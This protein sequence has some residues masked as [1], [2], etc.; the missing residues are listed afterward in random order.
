MISKEEILSALKKV[1]HPE[2]GKDIVSLGIVSDIRSDE[3]GISLILEPEKSND[4]FISSIK[5]TV[6]RVIKEN[7]GADS[8]I[9]SIEVKPRVKAEKKQ[10]KAEEFLSGIR[11]IIAISSG[12][13]GVGKTTVAVNLAIALARKKYSVG[14][15][16]A[17]VFGPSVPK[18]LGSEGFKPDIK[19]E[20]GTDYIV[21]LVKHGIKILSTGFFVNP[22]DAVIWRG[23]MASNFLKQ[24]MSQGEWGLLDYMLIDLPPGTGDIHLTLV[25]EVAVTGVIVVTT[26]Q[27][28]ALAD[29][30][31]GISMFR[32]ERINVPVLG[33]VENMSWFTPA[34]L[35]QNKYFIFGRDGGKKLAE[36]MEVPLLGQIP[37][38]QSICESGDSG[39]PVALENSPAGEAFMSL[40]DEVIEKVDRRNREQKPTVKVSM[41]NKN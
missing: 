24:L 39:S 10:E 27:E 37:I 33:L 14:L 8:V 19:R 30:V 11:N 2:K 35:P 34:E 32:S 15:L 16:D 17:D 26:P 12:K 28:V 1:I 20:N 13:G 4:P 36:K 21:P 25:Q 18:M 31:K 38:V 22:S 7:L 3:S 41:N 9:K 5:S 40:A 23:P 6:T 29:A